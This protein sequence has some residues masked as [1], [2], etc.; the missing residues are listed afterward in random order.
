MSCSVRLDEEIKEKII[1]WRPPQEA[2]RA[3]L[4]RIEELSDCPRFRFRRI[5][6]PDLMFQSD[7][8]YGESRP[9]PRD[10]VFTL[11]FRDHGDERVLTVVDCD[12]LRSDA[13]H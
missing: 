4:Q 3:V 1:R 2:I 7:V 8:F 13:V 10:H 9:S 11:T 12:R 6:P 5:S